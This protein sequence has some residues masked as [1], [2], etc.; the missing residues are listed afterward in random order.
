M[1]REVNGDTALLAAS[2][3]LHKDIVQQLLDHQHIHVNKEHAWTGRTALTTAAKQYRGHKIVRMLLSNPQIDVNVK[4]VFGTSAFEA[5]ASTARFRT[6]KLL[7][8]CPKTEVSEDDAW[9]PYRTGDKRIFRDDIAEMI[10]GQETLL[11]AGE[12]CCIN[13]REGMLKAAAD[14]ELLALKGKVPTWHYRR[15]TRSDKRFCQ[16]FS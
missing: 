10:T 2:H 16:K 14:G 6:V 13:V 7:L 9:L 15:G 12:T 8:R 5:A 4:D 3:R 1:N 11:N